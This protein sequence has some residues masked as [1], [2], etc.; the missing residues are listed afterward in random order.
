MNPSVMFWENG[1]ERR[2]RATHVHQAKVI[3]DSPYVARV[4]ASVE[5]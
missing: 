1:Q 5:F 4:I 2:V 3:H